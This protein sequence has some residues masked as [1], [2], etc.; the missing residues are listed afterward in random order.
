MYNFESSFVAKESVRK[1]FGV[2]KYAECIQ[3]LFIDRV[4]SKETLATVI[5]LIQERQLKAE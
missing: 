4:A 2:G 1:W 3:C 5:Q